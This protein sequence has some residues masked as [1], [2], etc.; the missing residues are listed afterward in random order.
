MS[1]LTYRVIKSDEQYFEYAE[2]AEELIEA[3]LKSQDAI[4]EYEL[5]YLLISD[6]DKKHNFSIDLDPIQLIKSLMD[7]HNLNQTDMVEIT[8]VGKSTV[9]EILNYKKRMS[10]SVIRNIA[11]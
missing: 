8:G 2:R 9:S 6:W 11:S 10:K 5:L 1:K 7:D 4:N 3:G